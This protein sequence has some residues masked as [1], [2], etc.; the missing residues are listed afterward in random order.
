MADEMD[1]LEIQERLRADPG[2]SYRDSVLARL[3]TMHSR[4]QAA[5][6]RGLAPAEY[7]EAERLAEATQAA[8][9]IVAVAWRAA[10]AAGR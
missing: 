1:L 7:R 2:G 10:H 3:E 8:A 6:R 4:A 9:R 5:M